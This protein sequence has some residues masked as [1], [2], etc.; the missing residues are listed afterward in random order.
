[1]MRIMQ[2]SIL[3][4]FFTL[5]LTDSEAEVA[6]INE[7]SSSNI[8]E[9]LANHHT[10]LLLFYSPGCGH[11]TRLMPEYDIVCKDIGETLPE[12]V[13]CARIDCTANKDVCSTHQIQGYP[14][15]KA[16]RENFSCEY[17][18]PRSRK[19]IYNWVK[20]VYH[21]VDD[22]TDPIKV[23][24][25]IKE[26]QFVIVAFM[27][28]EHVHRKLI[29]S[30]TCRKSSANF[31]TISDP[32][33]AK[34]LKIETINTFNLFKNGV[35]EKVLSNVI[36]E[37][38]LVREIFFSVNPLV[39]EYTQE[40]SDS[41][42]SNEIMHYLAYI[43]DTPDSLAATK[44]A[45]ESYAA[46]QVGKV[47]VFS[48]NSNEA[49]NQN[50]ITYFNIAKFP[51]L[52][53]YNDGTSFFYHYDK[54]DVSIDTLES[55][56]QGCID[57]SI[58]RYV[59]KQPVSEDWDSKSV[60]ILVVDNLGEV[61]VKYPA[62]GLI[63]VY[64]PWCGHCKAIMPTWDQIGDLVASTYPEMFVGKVDHT[65][66][67]ISDFNVSGYPTIFVCKSLTEKYAY[68]GERSLEGL[69]KL[70]ETFASGEPLPTTEEKEEPDTQLD[71]DE[72]FHEDL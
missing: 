16:L 17:T 49:N 50:V 67:D 42:F 61:F 57:G 35:F 2:A 66:N 29:Q 6:H 28:A 27:E 12:A 52:V 4:T 54:S 64:A 13:Q 55:F 70:V 21:G 32:E 19:D 62:G 47:R 59:K 71:D 58:S 9:R 7:I 30:A 34:E 51:S 33:I 45:L 25:S 8:E 46:S 26:N 65:E 40:T 48:V 3:L 31:I 10:T 72:D 23:A 36:D 56:V 68:T 39:P 1:M 20:S 24:E 69:T 44:D 15:I 14:T 60:K 43:Y 18:G 37:N 38:S 63:L 53:F 5:I 11:C 22:L 41:V